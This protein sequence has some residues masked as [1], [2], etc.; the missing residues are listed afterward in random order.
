MKGI[1]WRFLKFCVKLSV[2]YLPRLLITPYVRA[3]MRALRDV[4]ETLDKF[5][6]EIT[7]YC[8][9]ERKA[10]QDAGLS[11]KAIG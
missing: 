1:D 5:D 2:R 4:W 10:K 9:A 3:L 6:A 11:E 8:D 7:A